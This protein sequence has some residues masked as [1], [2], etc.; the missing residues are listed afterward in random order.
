VPRVRFL[1]SDRSLEVARGTLLV[2]AVRAAGLPIASACGDEL[3]CARCGVRILEGR[4]SR[5]SRLERETKQRNRVPSDLR[6]ACAIRVHGDLVVT[7]DYW[8]A[9]P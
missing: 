9:A 1:P 8:G 4:V 7:A 2:D 3:V 6:L 5:E